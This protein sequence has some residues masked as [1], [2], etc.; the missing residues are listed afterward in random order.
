[1]L[2]GY[3]CLVLHAHLPYIRHPEYEYFLE[4]NWFYEALTETY[5]PL[6]DLFERLVNDG[7]NFKITL[8]LSP[9]LTEMFNDELLRT[10][11]KR[12]L[13]G[14]IALTEHELKRIKGDI[15]FEPIVRMY[16]KRFKR[17]RHLFEDT[18]RKDLVSA[19][20]A[21][22]DKGNIEIIASAATHAFLPTLSLQPQAVK[23]QIKLGCEQY[24]KNFLRKPRGMWLPECGFAPGFDAYLKEAGVKYFFL[25]THGI[26]HANPLPQLSVYAPISCPSGVA[27]F[28]RDIESAKQVWSS[29]EG[30]PGDA[31]YRDFYRDIGFDLDIE[32]LKSHLHAYMIR[33]FT[34]LKYYRVTGKT[35]RK[36]PYVIRAA[37]KKA[38][39]H[40]LDFVTKKDLQINRLAEIFKAHK[41]S[42]KPI[43]TATYDAE[44][45]GH[46]W[47]EGLDWLESVLRKIGGS[48][49]PFRTIM[50]SQYLQ[51]KGS[52]LAFLPV[53]QP[54]LSS[55]GDKG[56]SEVWLNASN[57]FMYR[58]LLKTT[59][60]MVQLADTFPRAKGVLKRALNQ[61]AREVLLLQQSDWT[62]IMQTGT[63]TGYAKE[64]FR[65]HLGIFNHLY[66][67]IVHERIQAQ[68]LRGIESRD[69]IFRDINYRIFA[70][71]NSPQ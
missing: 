35:D 2:K 12:Y 59:E 48:Q 9:P 14:L 50:P 24:R 21:L 17:V 25:D 66:D 15:H 60:R 1:M 51:L 41:A 33:T 47:F 36:Q 38:K 26:V 68:W 65:E 16:R 18:Y 29:W 46:W 54:P 31:D 4:E 43:V 53:S 61:A 67:S 70:S 6:L 20:R 30:Y 58:H 19:F 42:I 45:F 62:F 32:H 37:R 11:Y 57:A 49:R 63:A 56:Y 23:V 3:L 44:L 22:Q 27:A 52:S 64:R 5:I 39:E 8:S 7:I 10:R 71:G 40:A 55:W 28:G 69:N 34:G 13:D